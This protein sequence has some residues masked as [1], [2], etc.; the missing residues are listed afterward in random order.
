MTT[1]GDAGDQR[2]AV[3]DVATTLFGVP[4]EPGACDRRDPG[5]DHRS[6]RHRRRRAAPAHQR[7]RRRRKT[8]RPSSPIRWPPGSRRSSA[9]SP[10]RRP[11]SP[12]RRRRPPTLPE[13]AR[14]ARRADR[15][16]RR[17]ACATA[18]KETLQAGSR[19]INPATGRPVFAF[20]LHQFLSKGDNVYVTLEPPATRHVTSTY[21]VA[22]PG[23][24]PGRA[25]RIL[26]PTAFCRECG[27]EYLVVTRS[28]TEG[29]AAVCGPPGQRRQ[30]RR[31]GQRLPVHQRRPA[32]AGVAGAGAD[33]R[34]AAVLLAD[35]RPG[36]RADRR[37][38]PGEVLLPEPVRVDVDRPRGRPGRGHLR[39]V[40]AEPVPVLPA[41]PHLLRAGP[42]QRLRQAGQAV[43][44]GPQLGDVADHREHRP[45]RC[46]PGKATSTSR[47]RKLL[48]FVDNRQDACLQAGHFND[49]VQVT[50]LRGALY[51]ALEQGPGRPDRRD[52]R[53]AGH[54]GTR[55]DHGRLRAAT[56]ARS[57]ARRTRRGGR[58]A[59]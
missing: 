40:R 43:G 4:V 30:R 24:Q 9:S 18:I 59:R 3:A 21:Q 54:R 31:R 7:S 22:A 34:P 17:T 35:L 2:Q 53:P 6:G 25:E 12:R 51:R 37:S 38:G 55:P 52:R 50:Q 26:V 39:G 42:R 14:A 36:G 23:R 11:T 49:F 56:R 47:A 32:L 57:T 16:G 20:R 48:A 27:Q 1:E 46:A 19:I 41:L 13:A 44:G 58:C 45:R 33:R 8:S 29:G 15:R 10:A 28:D 5:A